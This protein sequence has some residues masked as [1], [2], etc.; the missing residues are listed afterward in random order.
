ME[1]TKKAEYAV[2][3]LLDLADQPNDHF[4]TARDIAERQGIPT[5]FVPQIVSILCRAGWVE[6]M[7]GPGGGVRPVVN[8]HELNVLEI[9]E[10]VEGP[11]TI[12][13]VCLTRVHYA[14]TAPLSTPS[15]VGT[16]PRCN[17]RDFG[18]GNHWRAAGVK[19]TSIS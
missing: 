8:L 7:R 2:T 10:T 18:K 9:I 17:A 13:A 15:S 4:T 16:G 1:I 12:T 19:E 6:G 11:I 14:R 5:T 3:I